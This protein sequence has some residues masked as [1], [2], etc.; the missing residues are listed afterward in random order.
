M[1][2]PLRR[3]RITAHPDDPSAARQRR[4]M[5][6]RQLQPRG[7]CDPAVLEAFR[8]IPRHLFV[9]PAQLR[10]AYA[11]RALEIPAGQTISQPYI[12]ALMTQALSLTPTSKVL[13]IGSG[14]GYQ[15]A[16][17]ARLT[18]YVFSIEIV[19]ELHRLAREAWQACSLAERDRKSVV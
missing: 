8:T 5:I 17:L 1:F 15:A 14:S 11:D 18:P 9:P 3:N 4:D 12:V 19:E 13:E 2:G 6:E 16:I 10:E 7:I